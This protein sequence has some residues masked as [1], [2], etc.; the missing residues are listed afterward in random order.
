MPEFFNAI[1]AIIFLVVF[2]MFFAASD[3]V[4]DVGQLRKKLSLDNFSPFFKEFWG[5]SFD[6]MGKTNR[7]RFWL[8]VLQVSIVYF[9]LI[10]I[11]IFIYVYASINNSSF[12]A[13][14]IESL[15]RNISFISC[16]IMSTASL[17]FLNGVMF[18]SIGCIYSLLSTEKYISK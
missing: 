8:T 14:E 7:R 5:R 13:D 12:G 16:I 18:V 17:E 9:F 3:D 1:L 4:I 2:V 10:G 6:F 15:T 11:P